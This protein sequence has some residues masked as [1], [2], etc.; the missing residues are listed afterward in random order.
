MRAE[1]RILI[2]K[3]P[4]EVRIRKYPFYRRS[5]F[6]IHNYQ[7]MQQNKVFIIQKIW[8]PGRIRNSV[9]PRIYLDAQTSLVILFS[10]TSFFSS[11]HLLIL[12][13]NEAVL[14]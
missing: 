2:N 9:S 8:N 6:N 4:N 12:L 1:E 10:T 3:Y 13:P 14:G 7:R 11:E 5:D